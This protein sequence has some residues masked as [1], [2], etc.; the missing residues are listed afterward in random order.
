MT[1]LSSEKRKSLLEVLIPT[2][3]VLVGAWET[4]RGK[5]SMLMLASLLIATVPYAVQG[6]QGLMLNHIVSASRAGSFGGI[7]FALIAATGMLY[8]IR[9]SLSHFYAY[10]DKHLW[11]REMQ[12]RE[13]ELSTKLS[14]LDVATHEDPKFQDELQ[15]LQEYGA[16]YSIPNFLSQVISSSQ[17]IVGVLTATV[18]V[19]FIDWRLFL[20]IVI[21]SS[22]RFYVE[23]KYGKGI[24]G[25]FATQSE[26]RRYY[27]EARRHI[28]STSSITEIQTFQMESYFIERIK[29]ILSKFFGDQAIEERKKFHLL[30]GTQ[31]IATGALVIALAVLVNK[32]MSGNLQVGTLVFA[33]TSMVGLQASVS[34]FFLSLAGLS[35]MARPVAAY[36]KIM[37]RE[38]VIALP[39]TGTRLTLDSAPTIVFENVSFAYPNKPEDNILENFSLTINPGERMAI[40]GVNGAGK[41]TLIKLLCRFYDPT[42]GRVLINGIDLKD[43][44]LDDWYH[45]LALLSQD[46][47]T[48]QLKTWE[49]ISLGR[50]G[51]GRDQALIEYASGQSQ[52]TEFIEKWEEQ[53]EQQIG[54]QFGGINPSGGQKQ[55]LALARTFLRNALVTIL[56]EPTAHV[57]AGA[58][59]QIFEQLYSELKGGQTLIIISHR[60][61]TIRDADRICVIEDGHVQELGSHDELVALNATYAHLFTTQAEQYK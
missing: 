51:S 2:R 14:K 7:V 49:L 58:E 21:A 44:N 5:L 29:Q 23:L 15:L 48:Y 20:L 40:I 38:R 31:L 54:A 53:F 36:L 57:D 42:E 34:G 24:Y 39:A 8:L 25:I 16:A 37:N 45:V 28:Q 18:I 6:V 9:D 52:A 19:L 56:D 46:F 1:I 41:T 59:Q 13:I 27:Q 55:K 22:P 32:T 12:I 61:S 33:L 11:Y 10:S 60:F 4:S 47:T 50:S 35:R 43:V 3:F 26:D 17:N 30:L